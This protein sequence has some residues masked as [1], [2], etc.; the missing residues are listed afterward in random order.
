MDDE[1]YFFHQTPKEIAARLVQEVPI[2]STDILYEPFRGE[3]AFYDAFPTDNPKDWSELRMGR[4]YKDY[5]GEYDWVI[6]NPP[7]KL[8]ESVGR[9]VNAFWTLLDYYTD[10]ARK[11]VAFLANASCFGTLTPIRMKALTEKGWY[12]TGLRVCSIKKW[13]GRYYLIILQKT[14]NDFV[15]A[16]QGS[17]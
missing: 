16:I 1:T 6:T 2:T 13:S 14:P 15:R 4:D 12:I 3:G 10:R 7:F 8:D 5:V 17:W 9:R 11:G